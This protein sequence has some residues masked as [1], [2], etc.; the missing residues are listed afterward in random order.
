METSSSY[1]DVHRILVTYI[2]AVRSVP[3]DVMARKVQILA[4]HFDLD[5]IEP[6]ALV[7]ELVSTI[8]VHIEKLGFKIDAVREQQTNSL[9]YVFVNTRFDEVIQG[10]T[11]YSVPELDAIKQLIDEIVNASGYAF[12][13]L[14]AMAKQRVTTVLKQKTADGVYLLRRLVDDGWLEVTPRDRVL[15][16]SLCIAELR[17]YL[18]DKYGVFSAADPLGRLLKCAV[19]EDLVTMGRKCKGYECHLAF[20]NKCYGVYERRNENC[21]NSEC[22]LPISEAITVGPQE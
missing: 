5:Q 2:R 1:T 4:L 6:Q 7:R 15:L 9:T 19:C 16:S 12:N 21:T 17:T 14:Y 20:H 18:D 22:G 11:N 10:C 3:A 13:V 8:N